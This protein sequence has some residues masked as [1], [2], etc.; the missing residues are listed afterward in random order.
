MITV[1][2]IQFSDSAGFLKKLTEDFQK[3]VIAG[4]SAR[5][6]A[7][8]ALSGGSTP[9]PFYL[10]L[11]Q[12]GIVKSKITWWLGDERWV[13]SD[14]EQS[15]ERMIR[16]TLG[17]GIEDFS[18]RFQSWHLADEPQKAVGLFEEKLCHHLGVPPVFDVILLGIGGDGHT[19]SLFPGTSA[20][21]EQKRFAVVNE[22]PQMK[23]TR[24][25]LTY[26]TLNSAREA[27]FLVSGKDKEPMVT[28]LVNRDQSIP[29]ARL[30]VKKQKLYWLV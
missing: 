1:E 29:S 21:E 22:V 5:G 25:T 9:K 11:N 30:N 18:S 24:L 19:A 8:V 27:W 20:L 14:H 2:Q 12:S 3:A 10:H 13:P 28:R 23:S 7:H 15:N 4:I 16:E 6:V 17:K 26:P